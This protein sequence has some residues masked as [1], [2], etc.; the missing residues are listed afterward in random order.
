MEV[1]R[2]KKM[3]EKKPQGREPTYTQEYMMMVAK[4]VV[5]KGMTLREAAQTFGVSHGSVS[6]W[7]KMY[8]QG[9]VRS[10]DRLPAEKPDVKIYRLESHLK[11]LKQEIGELYLENLMLKKTLK[12]SQ[13]VKRENSSIITSESLDQSEEDAK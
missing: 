3:K 8:K 2:T 12:F 11:E 1:Y 10:S 7:K 9:E 6:L 5:E 13:Q 4:S